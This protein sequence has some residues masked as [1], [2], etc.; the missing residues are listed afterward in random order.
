MG[1]LGR[2]RK[3]GVFTNVVLSGAILFLFSLLFFLHFSYFFFDDLGF[4]FFG[5]SLR[6]NYVFE[7]WVNDFFSG[8][9][10]SVFD[11]FFPFVIPYL[12]KVFGFGANTLPI[13]ISL[14]LVRLLIVFAFVFLGKQFNA[15]A[16]ASILAGL[17]FV[18]NPIT[19]RF[20]NRF[21]ELTAWFFFLLAIAFF[22]KSLA[23]KKIITK[24]LFLSGFF[25]FS[26]A[27]S[28]LVPL[29][30]LF[31]AA[32]FLSRTKNDLKKLLLAFSIAF[33]LGAFWFVPFISFNSF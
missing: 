18:L 12:V 29:V 26:T 31:I 30:F 5:Y 4:D 33:L 7:G 21:Y 2:I 24:N 3:I 17:L 27:M 22:I 19:Y 13:G 1:F 28:H 8:V 6:Y 16:K 15:S 11:P 14:L 10:T 32:I 23:G 20:M 25:I 9:P